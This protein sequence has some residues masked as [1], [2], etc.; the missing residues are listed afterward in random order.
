MYRVIISQ[1]GVWA[2]QTRLGY[3]LHPQRFLLC[4]P[5]LP[6][7]GHVIEGP[8][9]AICSQVHSGWY[10]HRARR[11]QRGGGK[12]NWCQHFCTMCSP[13]SSHAYTNCP[14]PLCCCL[15]PYLKE[16]SW[17]WQTSSCIVIWHRTILYLVTR[18]P[19]FCKITWYCWMAGECDRN[20]C[21]CA[22][23]DIMVCCFE[24]LCDLFCLTCK[25]CPFQI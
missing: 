10:G 3:S 4:F 5:N 12:K 22:Y 24:Q 21:V 20:V 1:A 7:S 23:T 15:S 8:N 6:Q 19:D 25:T 2:E 17:T 13:P 9:T 11:R 14:L 16:A 18:H